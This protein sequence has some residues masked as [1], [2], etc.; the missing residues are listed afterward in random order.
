MSEGVSVNHHFELT[1]FLSKW[2]VLFHESWTFRSCFY[3]IIRT[4]YSVTCL[5]LH[6]TSPS[7]DS[8]LLSSAQEAK[9]YSVLCASHALRNQW[10]EYILHPGYYGETQPKYYLLLTNDR[11]FSYW[12]ASVKCILSRETC[13][14]SNFK[15][16]VYS[17]TKFGDDMAKFID[18][19]LRRLDSLI[20][21]L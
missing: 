21:G 9:A 18:L 7:A 8:F 15:K 16:L 10:R 6:F 14:E 5:P 17:M 11:M 13:F 3:Y 12:N 20:I 1:V 2:L 4:Q 19:G